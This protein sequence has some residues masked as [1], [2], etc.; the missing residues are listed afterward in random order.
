MSLDHAAALVKA[1][2]SQFL[3]SGGFGF[4]VSGSSSEPTDKS[5]AESKSLI[6]SRLLDVWKNKAWTH[7]LYITLLSVGIVQNVVIVL[8]HARSTHEQRAWGHAALVYLGWPPL[9]WMSCLSSM[10]VPLMYMLLPPTIPNREEMLK[11]D[12]MLRASYPRERDDTLK[13]PFYLREDILYTVSVL[14]TL[15]VTSL[16]RRYL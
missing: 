3:P 2:A 1:F 7:L 4:V 8:Q 15:V 11:R 13:V 9:V 12:P 5:D 6:M 16:S 14:Y 10:T